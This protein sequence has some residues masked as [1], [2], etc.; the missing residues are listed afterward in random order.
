MLT[1]S[2][3]RVQAYE[4]LHH[5]EFSTFLSTV[6][7]YQASVRHVSGSAI[8]PADF[9]SRNAPPCEDD[10]CQVC[11]FKKQAQDSSLQNILSGDE[12]LPFTSR[13]A[14]L[15]IQSECADLRRSHAHLQQDT[16]PSKKLSN[17]KDVKMY[18][19]VATI[20]KYG[21]LVVKGQH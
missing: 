2:K 16:R 12:R 7:R 13:T 18:L 21:L 20:A 8:L 6:S 1:D 9:A 17:V 4:K 10:V 3:P 11:A 19:N 14:W 5:G 15:T